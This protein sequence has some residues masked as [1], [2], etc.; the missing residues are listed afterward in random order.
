M[1]CKSIYIQAFSS[2]KNDEIDIFNLLVKNCLSKKSK[3][4]VVDYGTRFTYYLYIKYK[5]I[6]EK[7]R[8]FRSARLPY[9]EN[10]KPTHIYLNDDNYF[11]FLPLGGTDALNDSRMNMGIGNIKEFMEDFFSKATHKYDLI[12]NISNH[13][14][15][16]VLNRFLANVSTIAITVIDDNSVHTFG[17]NVDDCFKGEVSK[18][19]KFLIRLNNDI[20]TNNT[21]KLWRQVSKDIS[22]I[23]L[24]VNQSVYNTTLLEESSLFEAIE[25]LNIEE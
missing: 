23:D 21:K 2:R 22:V 1:K 11:S 3:I 18:Q 8:K 25:S 5:L 4:L 16:Y 7:K 15:R 10:S 14:T 20:E 13:P 19:N 12:I 24:K 6:T 9:R 17:F